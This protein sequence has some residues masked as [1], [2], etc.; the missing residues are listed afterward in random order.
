MLSNNTTTNV[1]TE[2]FTSIGGRVPVPLGKTLFYKIDIAARRTNAV[3]DYASFTLQ[4]I[5]N[6][7][8]GLTTDIGGIVETIIY[9]SNINYNV[10]ARANSVSNTINIY[11]TGV[12]GHNIAWSSIITTIEV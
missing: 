3:G 2:L 7:T 5:A 12:A 1:E 9:R 8:S 6:N 10:D 11:V 4:G